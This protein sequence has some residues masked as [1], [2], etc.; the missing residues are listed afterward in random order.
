VVAAFQQEMTQATGRAFDREAA[1]LDTG[2]LDIGP[3]DI[4]QRG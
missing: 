3:R 2:P 4:G 1:T